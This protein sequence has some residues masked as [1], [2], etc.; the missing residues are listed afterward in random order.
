[1]IRR[2]ACSFISVA[3]MEY[4]TIQVLS[5]YTTGQLKHR[6]VA[7]PDNSS[8]NRL[9]NRMALSAGLRIGLPGVAQFKYCLVTQPVNLSIARLRNRT[10][11]ALPGYATG[12]SR[13]AILFI[14]FFYFFFQTF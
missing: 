11:P 6:P 10:T 9:R 12:Q 14:Y 2:G 13:C 3:F 5:G 8:A 7:Q 4:C 1:M